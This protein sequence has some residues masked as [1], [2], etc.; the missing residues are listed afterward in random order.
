MT[1]SLVKDYDKFM[2]RLPEG[3]RDA[4]AERAKKNG[5]SM[6][7]EI[8]QIL[9]DA[10]EGNELPPRHHLDAP[11]DLDPAQEAF[12]SLS[13]EEQI[14]QIEEADPLQAAIE[15]IS[16]IYSKKMMADVRKV[17]EQ[18]NKKPT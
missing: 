9:Q 12:Y 16:D 15:R 5:R 17:I 13:R 6:N 1:V 7:S 14:E 2:L 4:I 10:L 11:N 8:V 3:M 18:F